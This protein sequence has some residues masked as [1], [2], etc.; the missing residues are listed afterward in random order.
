MKNKQQNYDDNDYLIAREECIEYNNVEE[1][2]NELK[3]LLFQDRLTSYGKRKMVDY[4]ESEI[5]RQK[6]INKELN[7]KI[8]KQK[9][10]TRL[11]QTL[12]DESVKEALTEFEKDYMSKQEIKDLMK[13]YEWAM[14]NYDS[15]IADYKQSQ[16][17][18]SWI[19]LQKL[20]QESEKAN[21]KI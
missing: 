5:E 13:K 12:T 17:V 6:Q 10:L 21:E 4:Y 3:I 8:E 14:N 7:K 16:A 15:S 1:D 20:L 11:A 2:I 19:T 9:K 18:G